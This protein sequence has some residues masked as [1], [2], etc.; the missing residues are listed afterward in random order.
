MTVKNAVLYNDLIFNMKIN[1]SVVD[2]VGV[3]VPH[4]L[5]DVFVVYYC[6]GDLH[7]V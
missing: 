7:F 2:I 6:F 3:L 5:Y 4:P 1:F